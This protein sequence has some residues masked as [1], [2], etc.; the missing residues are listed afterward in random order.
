VEPRDQLAANI[1][2]LRRDAELTQERLA[3]LSGTHP[4]EVSRLERGERDPQF[5][6]LMRIARGLGVPPRALLA[7]ID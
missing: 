6:T 4:S 2:R 3:E 7:N 1:R 5:S